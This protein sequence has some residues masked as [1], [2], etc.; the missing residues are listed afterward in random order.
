KEIDLSSEEVELAVFSFSGSSDDGFEVV[1]G[2]GCSLS[3]CFRFSIAQ[4]MVSSCTLCARHRSLRTR[5]VWSP[6]S[7]AWGASSSAS[8]A[9]PLVVLL[10]VVGLDV[11]IERFHCSAIFRSK[12]AFRIRLV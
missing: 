4:R 11:L 10:R 6:R 1:E 2:V 9:P 3:F 8:S 7:C 5:P 12:T